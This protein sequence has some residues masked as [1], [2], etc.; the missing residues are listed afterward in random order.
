M[1]DDVRGARFHAHS[2][3]L[4][5]PSTSFT[6]FQ[7]QNNFKDQMINALRSGLY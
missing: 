1:V 2:A 7:L 5:L 4:H 3:I 6:A